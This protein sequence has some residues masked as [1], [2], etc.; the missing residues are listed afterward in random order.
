MVSD[1]Y[2]TIFVSIPRTGGHTVSSLFGVV[3]AGNQELKGKRHLITQGYIDQIPTK[4][5]NYFTFT[6]VRN[7]FDKLVSIWSKA[8][9]GYLAKL[10]IEK[11]FK[12]IYTIFN[13]WIQ[14]LTVEDIDK[15]I[16]LK[17]QVDWLLS[18]KEKRC[19]Y[20]FDKVVRYENFE[21]ELIEVMNTV[22]IKNKEIPQINNTKRKNYQEYYSQESIHKV[23]RLY[24]DDFAVLAYRF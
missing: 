20:D 2:K 19:W 17:P 21:K 18:K 12:E 22:G 6:I 9:T 16:Q 15:N 10:D 5:K 3:A 13:R 4:W 8:N 24:K 1:E 23:L 7:P 14:N 11:D